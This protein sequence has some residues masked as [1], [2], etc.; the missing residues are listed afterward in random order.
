M[1]PAIFLDLQAILETGHCVI[2]KEA[3]VQGAKPST[4]WP[5]Q[6]YIQIWGYLSSYGETL[7]K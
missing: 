4:G 7:R 1:S 2:T 5:L 3:E 6:N